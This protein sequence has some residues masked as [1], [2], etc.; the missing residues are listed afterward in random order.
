[1]DERF[2]SY[3]KPKKT[4]TLEEYVVERIESLERQVYE[5]D[6][7]IDNFRRKSEQDNRA[8][9]ELRKLIYVD[10]EGMT[11]CSDL[12]AIAEILYNKEG[13]T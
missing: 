8:F 13:E 9:R 10:E 12:Y 6:E 5:K 4:K 3:Y 7:L 2:E 11:H 1:M